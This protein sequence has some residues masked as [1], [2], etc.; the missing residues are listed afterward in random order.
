MS[1][2]LPS[3]VTVHHEQGNQACESLGHSLHTVCVKKD[4][5]EVDVKTVQ[6]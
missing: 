2:H 4:T 3:L 5:I 6:K 1:L